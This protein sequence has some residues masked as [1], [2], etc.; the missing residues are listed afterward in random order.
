LAHTTFYRGYLVSR[1]AG[2]HVRK[3]TL[4]A[5]GVVAFGA[6]PAGAAV[7]PGHT[8]LSM[9]NLD[10][11]GAFGYDVGDDLTISV[12]RPG[13]GVIA[14][15]TAPAADTPDG[16]GMEL[17]HGPVGAPVPGDC[18]ENQIP[19]VLPGDTIRVAHRGGE[20]SIVVDDIEILRAPRLVGQDVVLEGVAR[21]GAGN[22]IPVAQLDSGEVRNT[23]PPRVRAAATKVERIAGTTDRWRA[24]YELNPASGPAYGVSRPQGV[25]PAIARDQILTGDHAMGYGHPIVP[26][27]P[28]IQLVDGIGGG[29]AALGCPTDIP[30]QRNSIE[31]ADRTAITIANQSAPLVVNG[32][33]ASD[34]TAANQ[35]R[36][37]VNGQDV[38]AAVALDAVGRTWSAEI[39]PADIPAADGRVTITADFPNSTFDTIDGARITT[40]ELTKDT[41]APGAPTADVPAGTYEGTRNVQLSAEDGATI[42]Y[43]NNGST[44]T[45]ASAV[46]SGPIA[47][48]ATQTLRARAFDAVGNPSDETTLPYVITQ[49]QPQPQVTGNGAAGVGVSVTTT[50]GDPGA[51]GSGAA[52]SQLSLDALA[53]S[54]SMSQRSARKNG[55]RVVMRLKQGTNVVRL[56]VYRKNRNGKRT[57][58]A[59]G[60]RAPKS[61]GLY[62]VRL[63][64]PKL[65]VALK[66]GNYEIEVTPGASQSDLG[67]T[68][69]S[70]FKVRR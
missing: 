19:D 51:S 37:A 10:F 68:S 57:L 26:L 35:V 67:K 44:P 69:R 14:S 65:R 5:I 32:L 17:N 2:K 45:A 23:A 16:G 47:V 24:T 60:F 7:A 6:A 3:A 62:R 40:L 49:P 42:R 33:A 66:A 20:D 29:G 38:Q 22:P 11:I 21:D 34:V 1:L 48:T 9:H 63:Q 25:A 39:A 58:L 31:G 59:Q 13:R 54:R 41:V 8:I 55:L 28:V 52:K 18:W 30:F 36:I 27:A 46:A 15:V 12:D 53:V 56:R 50:A 70:A 64:D 43:T 4:A 61:S